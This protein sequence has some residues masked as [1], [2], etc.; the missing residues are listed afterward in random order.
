MRSAHLVL[1]IAC[2]GIA[3]SVAADDLRITC[4][5]GLKIFLDGEFV[6]VSIPK[7]DGKYLDGLSTG[8]HTIRVEDV[9][10]SP[11]EFSVI[12]GPIPTQV[13]IGDLVPEKTIS[14]P[15]SENENLGGVED[16]LIGG[17]VGTVEISSNPQR[18]T[19][20]I[21]G[22]EVL[23]QEPIMKIPG[24]PA[25]DH[26]LRFECEGAV[27]SGKVMVDADEITRITANILENQVE[28]IDDDSGDDKAQA[29]GEKGASKK[30][31]KCIEYWVQVLLT[32]E[33]ELI[34]ASRSSL[35]EMGFPAYHQKLIT[36]G[37]EGPRPLYKLRVG[38]IQH[39]KMAKRVANQMKNV[40]FSAAWIVPQECP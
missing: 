7:Y 19:V 30:K 32:T 11:K 9:G 23:K 24:V 37:G 36:I 12:V 21:A 14:K 4:G 29:S 3:V 28:I 18:C 35:R 8:K 13:V 6:G 16:V 17:P 33:F 10:F 38:P 5:P 39:R 20:L 15:E 26:E 34:E 1:L 27:L 2:L 22:H 31:G 40:G 25:G